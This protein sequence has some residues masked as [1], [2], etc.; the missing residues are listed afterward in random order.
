MRY[1]K[2]TQKW[3]VTVVTPPLFK[4]LYFIEYNTTGNFPKTVFLFERIFYK[5]KIINILYLLTRLSNQQKRRVY[6][7][8]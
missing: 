1:E 5:M 6:F 8:P 4:W 7:N 2:N 3:F